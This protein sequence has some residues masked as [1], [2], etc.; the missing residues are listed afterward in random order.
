MSRRFWVFIEQE[1]GKIHPVAGEL[2]GVARRLAGEIADELKQKNETAVVEGILVGH[3]VDDLAQEAIRLGAER[4]YQVDAP[5][6]KY[7]LNRPYTEAL[8]T[9]VK[10]YKPEVFLIG[11]TTMGRDLAGAVATSL[12]TGLTA[13]CTQLE[14]GEARGTNKK[15]LLATRP[16]FG[17]N[18]IATIVCKDHLP[19]MATVRPRVFDASP[20]NKK[21][22]GEVIKEKI[23]VTPD[24]LNAQVVEFITNQASAIKLEYADVIV[25]GGRGLGSPK[26]FELIKA[27]ADELGGV[28]G[29]SRACVDAGWISYDH[30]VGQTGKTVRPKL[31][32]AAG[33]SGAIQHKVGMQD[34]DFILAINRDPSAP[35]F[36][37]ATVGLVGDL[38]EIIPALIKKIHASKNKGGQA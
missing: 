33:I 19:Q 8:K 16:A 24:M 35:I 3:E 20:V 22:R 29:S 25:S 34:S 7:Y 37:V 1:E 30:Q 15:L 11:A 4:V 10:K 6:F 12:K 18:V 28:V 38:Y 21:A 14:M 9:L 5:E 26:G 23:K 31:Y 32:I 27:L 2:L 17:G 36:S 13:D